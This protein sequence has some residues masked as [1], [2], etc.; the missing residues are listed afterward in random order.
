MKSNEDKDGKKLEAD[1]NNQNE[2]K[3]QPESLKIKSSSGQIELEDLDFLDE[4]PTTDD[5]RI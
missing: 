1:E 4:D 2:N 5:G 3:L